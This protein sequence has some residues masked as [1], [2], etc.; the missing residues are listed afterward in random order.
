MSYYYGVV[1]YPRCV[2]PCRYRTI[3]D[4][5]LKL[6]KLSEIDVHFM[7]ACSALWYGNAFISH[8]LSGVV[9]RKNEITINRI[10]K[11]RI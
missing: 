6:L 9:R 2:L 8:I 11:N 10:E 1:A 3:L 7:Y 5:L 4:V